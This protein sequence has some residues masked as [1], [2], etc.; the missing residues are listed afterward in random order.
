MGVPAG[1]ASGASGGG[2][3]GMTTTFITFALVIGIFYFL[4]I[5]PQNKRKKETQN[6]LSNLS[7]N[8]KIQTIGGIRGVVQD[9]KE[10]SVVVFSEQ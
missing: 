5:R 7:K 6:M 9:V 1:G 10:D 3:G 2:G 8:D 4:I